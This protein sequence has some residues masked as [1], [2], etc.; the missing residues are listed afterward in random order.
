[1]QS[2][3]LI[4]SPGYLIRDSAN[5]RFAE[6]G[7]KAKFM[8]NLREVSAEEFGRFDSVQTDRR[9][10]ISGR[11]WSGFENFAALFPSTMLTPTVGGKL[12]PGSDKA[13][14]ING[15]D[16]SRFIAHRTA[17]TEFTNMKLSVEEELWS[18]DVK[19][20]ALL[21][22]GQVPTDATAYYTEST[23]Q[24]YTAPS[25]PKS[26]FLAPVVTA[27]WGTR[28]GFTSIAA[29]K[30]WEI[31]GKFEIDWEPCY[32]DG[33]GTLDG[34]IKG[35]EGSAKGMPIGPTL[36]Q[37]LSNMGTNTVLGALESANSDDLVLTAS[38]LAITL[39]SAFIADDDG[40]NWSKKNHRI[41]DITWRTTVPF[42]S[43]VPQARMAVG[44][45]S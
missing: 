4:L 6:G 33:Y 16:G 42:S 17:L 2:S 39:P 37:I 29:R 38:G 24:S 28:T 30:G 43:G 23:S 36:A 45:G 44:N 15:Q 10:E 27:A 19:F 41:G 25:F 31:G 9:I 11:L 12:V 1:M 32:V 35:F 8:K 5:F 21:K 7:L 22:T 34:I 20:V 26:S 13:I 3:N 14:T 18:A 40:F